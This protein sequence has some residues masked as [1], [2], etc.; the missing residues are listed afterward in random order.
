MLCAVGQTLKE[1][2]R[3]NDSVYRWGGEEFLVV[4]PDT[5]ADFSCIVCQRL[6]KKISQLSVSNIGTITASIGATNFIKGD[7]FE[8]ILLRADEALYTAKNGGRN[9]VVIG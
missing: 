3:P 8:T 1:V 5:M 4:L 7:S 6:T 2:L 9:Q